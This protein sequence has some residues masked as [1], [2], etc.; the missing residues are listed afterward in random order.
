MTAASKEDLK[1][2]VEGN[3][4][5]AFELFHQ[6]AQKPGNK[7]FSPYSIS[8]A[9]GMTYAGARGNTAKEM[10]QTLHFTLP[11]ERLHPA[12][13]ELIRKIQ[14]ADEKRHYELAVA[15]SLW[16][17]KTGLSVDP[18]FLR[19]TE[20]DYQAGFQLVDFTKDAEGARRTINAWIEDKTNK[21]IEDFITKGLITANTRLVLTNAI[22]FR[23]EWSVPFP[24]AATKPEDFTSTGA[25]AFKVPMMNH[26]FRASY[27]QNA[28]FQLAQLMYKDDVVSMVVI[29][30]M[31]KDGLPEVE[32]K[33]SGNGSGKHWH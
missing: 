7:F 33:L 28:D 27:V 19:I 1:A 15:N 5:F 25:P 4:E 13:G 20:S 18:K 11:N 16:G 3:N 29:L 14:G 6:L 22:Y 23:G 26:T 30:P 21:K 31:K 17:D 12:F 8:T 2:V 9:L 10:A 24:K 32:R